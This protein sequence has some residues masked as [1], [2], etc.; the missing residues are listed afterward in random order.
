MPQNVLER[1]NSKMLQTH[2]LRNTLFSRASPTKQLRKWFASAEGASDENLAFWGIVR[3]KKAPQML[4][5]C[6]IAKSF[7]EKDAP[8]K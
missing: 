3:S 6:K 7:S 1:R 8:H 4:P 5:F 2:G